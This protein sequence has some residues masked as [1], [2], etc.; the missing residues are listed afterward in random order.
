ME[1]AL[2]RI[3]AV[4]D[5][6]SALKVV[7]R[8]IEDMGYRVESASSRVEASDLLRHGTFD[9]LLTDVRMESSDSGVQ[10]AAEAHVLRPGLP[11]ILMAGALDLETA[12]PA[13]RTG[14]CDYLTKPYRLE[15]LRVAVARALA[16]HDVPDASV[17]A[18][19][20]LSAAYQELKKVERT[21]EGMLAIVAHELRTPLCTARLIAD[22]IDGEPCTPNGET[23]RHI[24]RDSLARLDAAIED[25]LLH[26][27]LSG[28]MSPLAREP[29]ELEALVRDQVR[30]E[31]AEAAV[32]SETLSVEVSGASCPV[33]G[34]ARLLGRAV[35]HL[36]R[37][38]VRFNRRGGQVRVRLAFGADEAVLTVADEGE[39]IPVS[40][41]SRV[42]DAYYQVA[43]FM[44]RRV[45]GLGL[46]LAIVRRVFEGHGGGVS[47]RSVPGEGSVFRAWLPLS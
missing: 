39:G 17:D 7:R 1:K 14:A 19:Q 21:R 28:G 34:D 15:E 11:I 13:L 26:A 33:D 41:Q 30:A 18:R 47:V 29:V 42:F 2:T 35:R 8:V 45:G 46:G 44:T 38:A 27:R 37:N 4:D 6:P 9:A 43:D 31:A 10:L 5:D 3:L 36:L 16:S 24:L 20:E 25:V 32:L 23:A 22:Q 12:L 40:E